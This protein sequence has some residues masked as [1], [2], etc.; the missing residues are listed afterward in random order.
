MRVSGS[1]ICANEIFYRIGPF[2]PQL[3]YSIA[4]QNHHYK[5]A[6]CFVLQSVARHSP[7][8]AQACVE[9]GALEHLV[10]CLDEYHSEV[11]EVAA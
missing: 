10:A 8:L 9:A 5:K 7:T 4:E 2:S 6:A 3:V 1:C 11:K